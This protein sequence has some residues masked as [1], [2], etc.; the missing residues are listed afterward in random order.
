MALA[1]RVHFGKNSRRRVILQ[2]RLTI[3]LW[4]VVLG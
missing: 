1:L 2:W 3:I 4:D